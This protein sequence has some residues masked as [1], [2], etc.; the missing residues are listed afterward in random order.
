[1]RHIICVCLLQRTLRHTRIIQIAKTTAH[2]GRPFTAL[3]CYTPLPG[4][5][6]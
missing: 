3:L 2:A 5:K 6:R 1:M 4:R